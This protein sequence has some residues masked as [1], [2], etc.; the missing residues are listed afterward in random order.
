MGDIGKRKSIIEC[1]QWVE[2][3]QRKSTK[4]KSPEPAAKVGET[5][6]D[7]TIPITGFQSGDF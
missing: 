1:L 2:S 3:S 4:I 5:G 7:S 6:V